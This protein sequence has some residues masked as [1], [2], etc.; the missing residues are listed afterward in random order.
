MIVYY[1]ILTVDTESLLLTKQSERFQRLENVVTCRKGHAELVQR[2][3]ISFSRRNAALQLRECFAKC[4]IARGEGLVLKPDDPYFDFSTRPKSYASCNIKLKKE[5]IQGW[6]DVGDF[7]V[8]GASYDAAKA[9]TYKIPNLNWTDFYIGCLENR[10]SARARTE[11]PR[12]MV[13]NIVEL[14]ETLL[15][16]FRTHCN[17]VSIPLDEN[18]S[19]DLKFRGIGNVK[20]PSVVFPEPVVFDMRCFSFD[21]EANSRTWSMRFPMVNKIHFDR[22][23]LDTI[24][25]AELQDAARTATEAADEVDSQEMRRWISA[26]E[27]ADP[28]GIAVD[29]I[30][31][32]T[33][34]TEMSTPP[35]NRTEARPCSS[36]ISLVQEVGLPNV[37]PSAQVNDTG[38]LPTL[39]LMTPPRSSANGN[40]GLH[41]KNSIDAPSSQ[42]NEGQKRPGELPSGTPTTK[43]PR[44]A[45]GAGSAT[46]SSTRSSFSEGVASF[47]RERRPL[48]TIDGNGSFSE[49]SSQARV[50]NATVLPSV[51]E[52]VAPISQAEMN[53][54]SSATGS[55]HTIADS[56]SSPPS[57][58]TTSPPMRQDDQ[59]QEQTHTV[60]AH[61]SSQ[62]VACA[63]R[64]SKCALK[65]CSFLLSPCISNYAWVTENLLRGHGIL[66]FA[67]EPKL[68][69]KSTVSNLSSQASNPR[70][71]TRETSKEKPSKSIRAARTRRICLVETRRPGATHEFLRTIERAELKRRNGQREWIAVYDWRILEDFTNIE[72]GAGQRGLDPWRHRYVGIA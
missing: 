38:P 1:D 18:E 53:I 7:A 45:T 51:A 47:T 67:V 4:I 10:D 13:T 19:L 40:H 64:G 6:G 69:A 48:G 15:S 26:L 63:H 33:T 59:V 30:S 58:S 9:K 3:V 27:K 44:R 28:R 55:F 22:S 43:R 54:Q 37:G 39:D 62:L 65:D 46:P 17:P 2:Q 50:D 68:W 42:I 12:F 24:T 34:S 25:F 36:N 41:N 14:P 61:I 20:K 29:A 72:T 5:Y 8:I 66:D 23:Y 71:N 31:Q 16:T 57:L 70:T 60:P 11:R 35:R 52:E 21:K 49:H 32:E 56:F